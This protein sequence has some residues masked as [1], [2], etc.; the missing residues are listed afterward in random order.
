[1]GN[2]SRILGGIGIIGIAV[3]MVYKLGFLMWASLICSALAVVLGAKALKT[4]PT[5]K[6]GIGLG[7]LGLVGFVM[8]FLMLGGRTVESASTSGAGAPAAVDT[9]TALPSAGTAPS[10]AQAPSDPPL[11]P[12]PPAK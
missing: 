3:G 5:A 4:S 8:M 1:M 12:P 6:M 9:A 7:A 10:G 2:A 11:A